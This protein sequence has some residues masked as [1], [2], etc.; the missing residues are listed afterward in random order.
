MGNTLNF[1]AGTSRV[2][3]LTVTVPEVEGCVTETSQIVEF[4]VEKRTPTLFFTSPGNK[5][6]SSPTFSLSASTPNSL[7]IIFSSSNSSIVSV[8]DASATVTGAGTVSIY[9]DIE[10]TDC[11][12]FTRMEAIITVAINNP[13]IV[14]DTITGVTCT[15]ESFTLSASDISYGQPIVYSSSNPSVVSVVGNTGYVNSVGT[16]IVTARVVGT[17]CYSDTSSHQTLN[18]TKNIPNFVFVPLTDVF[19]YTTTFTLS[20]YDN[21]GGVPVFSSSDSSIISIS[22]FV[23]TVVNGGG[24]VTISAFIPESECAFSSISS[25]TITLTKNIPVITVGSVPDIA[26][27]ETITVTVNVSSGTS[28]LDAVLFS[29][30]NFV[31]SAENLMVTGQGIGLAEI[32]VF[33]E[34]D[35]C[36]M[37]VSSVFTVRVRDEQYIT[38]EEIGTKLVGMGSFTLSASASSSLPLEISNNTPAVISIVGTTVNLLTAG[39]G[40]VTVKQMGNLSYFAAMPVTKTFNI[41]L[42]QIL[43]ITNQ[44]GLASVKEILSTRVL[45]SGDMGPLADYLSTISAYVI[46]LDTS[47]LYGYGMRFPSDGG[48]G[49]YMDTVG[50]E[51][52]GVQTVGPYVTGLDMDLSTELL[53]LQVA[54]I[55]D[56][57]NYRLLE[58]DGYFDPILD[59]GPVMYINMQRFTEELDKIDGMSGNLVTMTVFHPYRTMV[60]YHID[61]GGVMTK[62]DTS[63]TDYMSVR[64]NSNEWVITV[65]FSTIV[66]GVS[67]FTGDSAMND[68]RDPFRTGEYNYNDDLTYKLF[69]E[70][71]SGIRLVGANEPNLADYTLYLR[72]RKTSNFGYRAPPPPLD[73][74]VR[75]PYIE[76]V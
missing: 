26:I 34:G 6:C 33:V 48:R 52:F 7:P 68:F 44:T 38:F 76:D 32:V 56:L 57:A 27:G 67:L 15:T 35:A 60:I 59:F 24:T 65:P 18:I 46:A 43:D 74:D 51:I 30:D 45:V 17:A 14:F 61:D 31:A 73:S 16:A 47:V 12:N 23:G 70:I 62:L 10:E 64:L 13:R 5:T 2:V 25:Q 55:V 69:T 40:S 37:D 39:V 11:Y 29:R 9:A 72:R 36:Y 42:D 19:C 28:D 20:A 1:I 54:D 63:G 3:S 58:M 66:T 50:E 22:G 49:E 4:Y 53:V 41:Y 8:T 75:A 71:Q 21:F